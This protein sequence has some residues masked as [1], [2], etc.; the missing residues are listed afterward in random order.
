[1]STKRRHVLLTVGV[2]CMC[3][4]ALPWLGVGGYAFVVPGWDVHLPRLDLFGRFDDGTLYDVIS[5]PVHFLALIPPLGEIIYFAGEGRQT[6]RPFAVFMFWHF[7][8]IAC[9][10]LAVRSRRKPVIGP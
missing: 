8:G 3:L 10:W 7:V 5:L 4:G 1:M 2:I 6:V 9:I